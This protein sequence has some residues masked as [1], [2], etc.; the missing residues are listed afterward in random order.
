MKR[1]KTHKQI[2][3]ICKFITA[4]K[5]VFAQG[6]TFTAEWLNENMAWLV[7]NLKKKHPPLKHALHQVKAYT[8]LNK[9]LATRGLYIKAS[10]YYSTFTILPKET[11]IKKANQYSFEA[12]TKLIASNNLHA[13]INRYNSK[14][15]KPSK[16]QVTRITNSL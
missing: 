9:V 14:W 1:I 8:T 10:N 7:P 4:N 6:N 16:N 12:N 15:R 3:I 11:T 5:N 2:D 13:G